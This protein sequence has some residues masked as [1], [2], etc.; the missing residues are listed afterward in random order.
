MELALKQLTDRDIL[1]LKFLSKCDVLTNEQVG[2][3]YGSKKKYHYNRLAEL[4]R[5][6]L[7]KR[8]GSYNEITL[9]GTTEIGSKLKPLKLLKDRQRDRKVKL[10]QV[11]LN[12]CNYGW[13][14]LSSREFKISHKL[15]MSAH[16]DGCLIKDDEKYAIYLLGSSPTR[17]NLSRIRAEINTLTLHQVNSAIVFYYTTKAS[18][19]FKEVKN[20]KIPELLLFKYPDEIDQIKNISTIKEGIASRMQDYT[21]TDKRYADF[22]KGNQ[23][24]SVLILNDL[25]KKEQLTNYL[26]Y[27]ADKEYKE[28]S[29]LTTKEQQE[30]LLIQFPKAKQ[31]LSVPKFWS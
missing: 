5:R 14:F 11:F 22:E 26:N 31:I 17:K 27:V 24:I 15:K 9:T 21:H 7:I 28:V 30:E 3:L 2:L 4:N 19:S 1:L 23:Y 20:I 25:V 12:L 18:E 13:D 8:S 16:V 10:T 6:G 29:I